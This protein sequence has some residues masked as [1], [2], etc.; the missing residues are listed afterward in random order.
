MR[1]FVKSGD[2]PYCEDQACN[3]LVKPDI[4]FFGEALPQRFHMNTH[5]P[6]QA[7]V[8]IIIGT[9]LTVHPFAS[10]P[11]LALEGTPR[12]LL[13]MEMV[14][15]LG[16]RPDDVLLLGDCDGQVRRL[17]DELGWR[18]ELEELY[19]E[20]GGPEAL[21]EPA[22][23]SARHEALED[24]VER[25]TAEVEQALEPTA[26]STKQEVQ[27]DEVEKL[28]SEVE[29]ALKISD[30]HKSWL[31][32]HLSEKEATGAATEIVVEKTQTQ[33]QDIQTPDVEGRVQQ[34]SSEKVSEAGKT[35]NTPVISS[36]AAE[37]DI[38]TA[39]VT[40][41]LPEETENNA[42]PPSIPVQEKEREAVTPLAESRPDD[43]HPIPP[44]SD[45]TK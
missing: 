3:G 37:S 25:L 15:S 7:D 22:T 23:P 39:H 32:K 13:N 43:A 21:K 1:E 36:I 29:Q 12:V 17:A 2:I 40:S 28:T 20:V 9:S 6:A 16:S 33:I 5:V 14:G 27:D 24:E 8:L 18:D 30:G 35:G 11:D 45:S 42:T 44:G 26:P 10:L 41:S 4:T 38:Q 31:E 34:S 19:K